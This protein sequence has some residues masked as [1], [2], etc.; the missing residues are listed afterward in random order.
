MAVTV[1]CENGL[2]QLKIICVDIITVTV[3]LKVVSSD[4]KLGCYTYPILLKVS[5]DSSCSF[6][7]F[8]SQG[9]PPP[10]AFDPAD[11]EI[12]VNI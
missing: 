6:F 8:R 7:H 10:A 9:G 12:E 1:Y 2:P 4:S 5:N 3:H 11:D